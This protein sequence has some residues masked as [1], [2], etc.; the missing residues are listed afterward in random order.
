M[1]LSCV[2]VPIEFIDRITVGGTTAAAFEYTNTPFRNVFN[3]PLALIVKATWFQVP[4]IRLPL[5]AS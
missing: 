2:L 4:S 5:N 1:V 3:S